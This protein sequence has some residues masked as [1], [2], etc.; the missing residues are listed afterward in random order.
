MNDY[1]QKLFQKYS[2]KGI[3]VDTNILL[4][5]IIGLVDRNYIKKF[6]R[7]ADRFTVDDF[8]LIFQLFNRFQ[9]KVTTTSILTEVSNLM[10]QINERFKADYFDTF[11]EVINLA[12]ERLLMSSE[13]SDSPEFRKFGLTD[14]VIARVARGNYL[15]LTDD[16][17]LYHY[18]SNVEIDVI[19]FNYIRKL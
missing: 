7:T 5:W 11:S 10:G 4:L 2:R 8:D 18:L 17:P 16:L 3:L 12:D 19:N 14:S 13:V 9:V 6:K 1:N 15:V